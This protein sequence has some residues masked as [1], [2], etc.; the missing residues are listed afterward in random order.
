MPNFDSEMEK[1]VF[2]ELLNQGYP[3]DA[4]VSG[5]QVFANR[6][7]GIR[8]VSNGRV[9]VDFLVNDIS[10]GLPMM[11]IEVKSNS[12][13]MMV[14]AKESAYNNLKKYYDDALFPVKAIAALFDENSKLTFVD[15]TDAIK[16]NNIALARDNYSLPPYD[17]LTSGAKQKAIDKEKSNQK[18][19]IRALK[20]L[21]WGVLPFVCLTLIM[22]DAFDV[23]VLSSLRLITIGVGAA[24][25][26]IPCFKEISIGEFTLK[27]IIDKPKD[28]SD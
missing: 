6:F 1:R 14:S 4:I 7:A 12:G 15:F 21:C 9:F 23:Y 10:T 20:W 16:H 13:F 28:D 11:I 5:G 17:L 2:Y 25:V 8:Q 19:T 24:V 26:L 3:G 27:S 18:K 22:L